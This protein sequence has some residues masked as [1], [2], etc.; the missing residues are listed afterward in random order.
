MKKYCISDDTL[1]QAIWHKRNHHSKD[2]IERCIFLGLYEAKHGRLLSLA[3]IWN[4]NIDIDAEIAKTAK[5]MA[6]DIVSGEV[7]KCTE[8]GEIITKTQLKAEFETLK[9]EEPETYDYNFN[10]F[11]DNCLS[12]NG[13]L[14]EIKL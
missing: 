1:K 14:E 3:E 8:T 6:S 9:T 7:Y 12:K 11:I 4:D 5:T 13:F 2:I 10:Q